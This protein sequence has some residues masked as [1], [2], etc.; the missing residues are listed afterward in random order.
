M[1]EVA[2][3]DGFSTMT[4]PVPEPPAGGM[5]TVVGTVPVHCPVMV[6]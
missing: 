6:V 3:V 5:V 4:V 1:K 2:E